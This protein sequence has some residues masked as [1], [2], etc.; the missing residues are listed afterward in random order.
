MHYI[1]SD[2]HLGGGS[3]NEARV[4]EEQ[5]VAWLDSVADSAE[6][7]FLNG[8]I[9]DF[10]FEYKRVVPKGFVRSLGRIAALADKGVRVVFM[11]G[12]HDQWVR[13]Y[14]AQECDM[15]IYTTP[16]I[17]EVE[18]KKIYL[19]HGDSLNVKGNPMLRLMNWT[20]HSQ[21]IRALFS[22]I[23]HPDL[24]LKFGHWW[25]RSS[26]EK[27]SRKDFNG[28][29]KAVDFLL[30]HAS[31]VHEAT[32]CDCYIFGHLHVALSAQTANGA[33]VIFTNDWSLEPHCIVI[34]KGGDITLE[35][36]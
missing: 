6:T 26:R 35:K 16:Q 21:F 36:I 19:A 11:T 7:I 27:H 33:R 28:R 5:F 1:V 18:G 4:A 15:E 31:Q 12:N 32:P 34:G 17:F 8:D 29:D 14:F 24:A 3:H 9:F 25:S 2:I 20:F 22:T 10:W 30:E 13:D 23:V